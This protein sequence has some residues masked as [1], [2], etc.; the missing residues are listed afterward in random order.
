M[1]TPFIR[2][3]VASS[4][5][6]P[7]F[8]RFW[9]ADKNNKATG[10]GVSLRFPPQ[11]LE[12]HRPLRVQVNQDLGRNA[13]V[14]VDGE[15]LV[16]WTLSGSHGAG[17][18]E[19]QNVSPHGQISGGLAARY[20]LLGLFQDWAQEN[21]RR[22]QGGD[23]LLKL[24]MTTGGG[25]PSEM[26]F[27]EWVIVP[28][29]LPRDRRGAAQPMAWNWSLSFL[30]VEHLSDNYGPAPSSDFLSLQQEK[31]LRV[32]DVKLA[33]VETHLSSLQKPIKALDP[34][35][36]LFGKVKSF[37]NTLRSVR[38]AITTALASVKRIAKNVTDMALG[39]VS[40]AVGILGDIAAFGVDIRG[41]VFGT[42]REIRDLMIR[43]R[44]I[45]GGLARSATASGSDYSSARSTTLAVQVS[46]SPQS[47]ALRV[48]GDASRWQD[49]AAL[50]DLDYPY[51]DF[52]G[53]AGA[54]DPAY[55]AAGK[56]VLGVGD[57]MGL[58]LV[59]GY[60]APRDP[61]GWDRNEN[62][63]LD[64]LEGVANLSA[65]LLRRLRTP[66]AWL[67]YHPEYGAGLPQYVGVE[68]MV[69]MVLGLRRTVIRS[70]LLDPRVLSV[71]FARAWV[72][73]DAVYVE[74]EVQTPLGRVQVAGTIYAAA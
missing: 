8:W 19:I 63:G 16:K 57:F 36:S 22:A 14:V 35:G 73:G 13:V 56:R 31:A 24:I 11:A 72:D 58:P 44:L 51:L 38:T 62:G 66:A 3:T 12:V 18:N 53:P 33:A 25:G 67:P 59:D 52:S 17:F 43:A 64:V 23:D 49:L 71:T 37:L 47:L 15:G 65:A 32:A 70:L 45:A 6:T 4:R 28:E 10:D 69:P 50:N 60:E 26:P 7:A 55:A 34:T 5:S 54:A 74:S 29:E 46:D 68:L 41:L 48:Y 27:D 1:T 42:V 30:G 40:E 9:I 21:V 39:L 61:I 2:S 20:A